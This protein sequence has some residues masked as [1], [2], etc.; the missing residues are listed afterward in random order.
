MMQTTPLDMQNDA[1][2]SRF[3][4]SGSVKPATDA[5]PVASQLLDDPSL[6]D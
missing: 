1:L 2:R 5:H 4:G 3:V 6:A